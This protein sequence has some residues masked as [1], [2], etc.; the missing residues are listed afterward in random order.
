MKVCCSFPLKLKK[1]V[2]ACR[3]RSAEVLRRMTKGG[4]DARH[5]TS[6]DIPCKLKSVGV[7]CCVFVC[8]CEPCHATQPELYI[9]G[10]HVPCGYPH[11]NNQS[12]NFVIH[13]IQFC[14]PFVPLPISTL[15]LVHYRS[16]VALSCYCAQCSIPFVETVLLVPFVKSLH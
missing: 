5:E 16:A 13:L 14:C 11:S 7:V 15:P 3:S 12:L 8:V 2:L 1:L 10:T 6:H 9:M 4:R